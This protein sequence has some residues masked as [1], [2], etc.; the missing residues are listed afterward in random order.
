MPAQA[1]GLGQT[2]ASVLLIEIVNN[3][4]VFLPPHPRR[5]EGEHFSA[6]RPDDRDEK[7]TVVGAQGRR[8][9]RL[10]P[11]TALPGTQWVPATLWLCSSLKGAGKDFGPHMPLLPPG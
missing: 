7:A 11:Q 9:R 5:L 1:V 4:W 2:R 3:H 8:S 10:C 6:R